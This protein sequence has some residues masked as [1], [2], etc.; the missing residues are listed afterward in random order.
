MAFRRYVSRSSQIFFV[1]VLD[2][3]LSSQSL[4]HRNR[5]MFVRRHVQRRVRNGPPIQSLDR[6]SQVFLAPLLLA[7]AC[8]SQRL[9]DLS[10]AELLRYPGPSSCYLQTDTSPREL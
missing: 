1:A 4:R 3:N 9:I 2:S 6:Y 7:S 8:E 5:L 10:I